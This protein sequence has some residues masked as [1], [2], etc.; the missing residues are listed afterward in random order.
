[1][2]Q[3]P[4][5]ILCQALAGKPEEIDWSVFSPADWER[6]VIAASTGHV[7]SI[8]YQV[9][10]S[11]DGLKLMPPDLAHALRGM[12]YETTTQNAVVY[13]ELLTILDAF[14]Q[15]IDGEPLPVVGLKGIELASTLYPTIG[16]RPMRD[17]DLLLPPGHITAAIQALCR[18]GYTRANPEMIPDFYRRYHHHYVGLRGGPAQSVVVELHWQL[19]APHQ[20]WRP[21]SLEWF[22][23]QSEPWTLTTWPHLARAAPGNPTTAPMRV[24]RF[25]P[26]ANLLYLAAHLGMQHSSKPASLLWFY[27]LHLLLSQKSDGIDWDL[28]IERAHALHWTGLLHTVLLNTQAFFGTPLPPNVLND[29]A[30][31]YTRYDR[32]LVQSME[33]PTAQRAFSFWSKLAALTWRDRVY[34]LCGYVVPHP[35]YIRWR[36]PDCASR[37]LRCYVHHWL[38]LARHVW[39][40][41]K[42]LF[43]PLLS[44]LP[45]LRARNR[46]R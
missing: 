4:I 24:L 18:L 42:R 14:R 11:C 38:T 40:G 28:L 17:I 7:A 2:V 16:L 31:Q 34:L 9:L 26:T 41:G 43:R 15:T 25:T 37:L 23:Q 12:Y 6:L 22:W 3:S 5:P 44:R 21:S 33:H 10:Q 20:H 27:D 46:S 35:G 29:L 32:H 30:A 13:Q 45:L 19:V 36:Y 39:Q 1:M 8:F